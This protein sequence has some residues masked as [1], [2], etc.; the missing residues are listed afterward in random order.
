VEVEEPAVAVGIALLVIVTFDVEGV[1]PE[2]DIVQV[3]V[4]LVP[5]ERPVIVVVLDDEFVIVGEAPEATLH[6]PVPEEA[7]FAAI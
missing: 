2:E 7:A 3:S 5:A 6:A 1:H 4:E